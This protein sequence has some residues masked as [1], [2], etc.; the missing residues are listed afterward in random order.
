MEPVSIRWQVVERILEILHDLP[1]LDGVQIEP[2]FPGDAIQREAIWVNDLDGE[3]TVPVSKNGTVARDDIFKVPLEIRV[4]TAG[5]TDTMRRLAEIIAA[6]EYHIASDVQLGT[7][8]GVVSAH[9][10]GERQTA[11]QVKGAGVIGFGEVEITIH[12][13]SR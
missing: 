13:A 5:Y 7:I 10:S 6:I 12:A 2:G 4:V 1:A 8:D 9:I 3:I 11:G